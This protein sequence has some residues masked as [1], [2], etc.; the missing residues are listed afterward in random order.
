LLSQYHTNSVDSSKTFAPRQQCGSLRQ[1][2]SVD[3][4]AEV[5]TPLFANAV[6][7]VPNSSI[8]H[9]RNHLAPTDSIDVKNASRETVWHKKKEVS[10][11]YGAEK[12]GGFSL[13]VLFLQ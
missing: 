11:S 13:Y 3:T 2:F 5:I 8:C 1:T 12:K 9:L 7:A 10:G 4:K 6:E